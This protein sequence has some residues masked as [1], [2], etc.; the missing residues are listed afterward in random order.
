MKTL[1]IIDIDGVLIDHTGR[2]HLIP[3][4]MRL[5][6]N[7]IP[8]QAAIHADE[9]II[10]EI[11]CQVGNVIAHAP[12][13]VTSVYLTSRLELARSAT[14]KQ[15]Q[16]TATYNV[17]PLTTSLLEMRSMN[18]HREPARFKADM[19]TAL[20]DAHRPDNVIIIEDTMDNIKAMSLVIPCAVCQRCRQWSTSKHR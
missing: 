17:A 13:R 8:H 1:V 4:D 10:D 3:E 11:D 18:D 20:V 14:I 9:P 2:D 6:S 15:L 5:N 7:W 16:R 19:V 12:G